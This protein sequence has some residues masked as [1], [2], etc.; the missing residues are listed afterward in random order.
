MDDESPRDAPSGLLM[1]LGYRYTEDRA[2]AAMT[3]AGFNDITRAQGRLLAGLDDDGT[4]LVVL[5]ERARIAKQ[6]AVALIDRL[7]SNGYVERTPD[8][9]DGRARLVRLTERGWEMV[10][11]ARGAVREVE[12]EWAAHLGR[13]DA[14]RLHEVLLRLRSVVDPTG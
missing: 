2:F 13:R 1:F 4:R 11:V 14:A 10:L 5:A 9:L 12:A 3:A 7:E 6:T 8:P